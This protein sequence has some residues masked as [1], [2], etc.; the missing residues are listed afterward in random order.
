MKS[1]LASNYYI[2]TRYPGDYPEFTINEC[3]DA[4]KVAINVKEFVSHKIEAHTS[5]EESQ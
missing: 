2:E 3:E 1:N 5:D 4:L